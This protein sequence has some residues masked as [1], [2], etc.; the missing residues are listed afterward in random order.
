VVEA[1]PIGHTLTGVETQSGKYLDGLPAG[2]PNYRL[3]LPFA[4]ESTGEVTQFTNAL[5]PNA[6]SRGVFTFHR[7]EELVRLVKL[8][9]QVRT[10]LREMPPLAAGHLWR[11]Q[12]ESIQNLETSLA[13]NRPRALI[14]MATG[15]GKTFTAVNRPGK[16]HL[17]KPKWN[18]EKNPE[19]RWRSFDYDELMKRDKVNLDIFWLKDT[20]L[21]DS[22][23]LPA[24]DV[25]AQEIADDLQTALEQFTAIAEKVKG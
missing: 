18:A 25:L 7:P 15:S 3:P 10:R 21:E 12:I 14:Q 11:V 8:D 19:G 16:R 17:R 20:S 1:K 6:R 13:A 24:P 2:L 9:K 22:D 23:D 5:E 4:Y